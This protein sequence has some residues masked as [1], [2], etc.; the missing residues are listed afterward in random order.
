MGHEVNHSSAPSVEVKNEWSYTSS[1]PIHLHGIERGGF[2]F[3]SVAFGEKYKPLC[4]FIQFFF[5]CFSHL[6]TPDRK[7]VLKS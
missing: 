2:T 4:N 6:L 3:T 1:S 7:A 5:T